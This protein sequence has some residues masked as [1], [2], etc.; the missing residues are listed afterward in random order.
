MKLCKRSSKE[1]FNKV[2]NKV[3]KDQS[4]NMQEM[5]QGTREMFLQGNQQ[6]NREKKTMQEKQ[7]ITRQVCMQGKYQG[8]TQVNMEEK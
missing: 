8:S 3:A 5:K 7:Q 1:L 6:G 2:L 4:R